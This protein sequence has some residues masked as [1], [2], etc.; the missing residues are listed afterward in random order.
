MSND[1]PK[2]I[3]VAGAAGFVGRALPDVFGDDYRLVGLT[4][5]E[6]RSG[7]T[8]SAGYEWR[9]CDLF[10]RKQTLEAVRGADLAVYMVH[11]MRP[12]AA[13]TQGHFRDMDLI[14]ADNFAR[15]VRRHGVEHIAY[16]SGIIPEPDQHETDHLDEHLASR[17]EVEETLGTYGA[18]VT[19][20]RAGIVIGPGG[21]L[22]EIIFRLV[23]RLPVMWLPKWSQ[24]LVSPIARTDL[25]ELVRFVLEHPEHAGRSWDVGGP[26]TVTY[27]QILELAAELLGRKRT[28]FDVPFVTPGL[29]T[30]WI[31]G[32][33][34]MPMAL[35]RPMIESLRHSKLPRDFQLQEAAGQAPISVRDA[36]TAAIERRQ[37]P[38][39][40]PSDDDLGAE[41]VRID[42]PNEVRSV[43]RL[44]LP[45]GRHARWV[46]NAYA[47]W[48]PRFMRPFMHVTLRDD[49]LLDFS[50]RLLPWPILVLELDDRVSQPDRQL[51]WIRGGLLAGRQ[52][53]GRLEFREVL[54]G[55]WVL[56]AIH[57]FRPRLPW[58]I[59]VITQAKIHLFVMHAFARYLAKVSQREQNQRQL[60][61]DDT[62]QLTR[63]DSTDEPAPKDTRG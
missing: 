14:C 15:A 58:P 56:A 4:R 16:V 45:D 34:G 25:A 63:D 24:N 31:S 27:A 61:R 54:G 44:P 10:S 38:D 49:H 18:S 11:S 52:A 2:T 33:T 42:E 8:S 17:L 20:L 13:L 55:K 12:S 60:E 26:D 36:M 47:D 59:Y 40:Q 39:G 43:Q 7:Q 37:Q 1:T 62:L 19:T 41:L 3:V 51:Y 30:A 57:E 32:F 6:T 22:T 53:G 48:L 23:E 35:V 29:S 9:R 28:F 5:G 46:A 50:L 21:D